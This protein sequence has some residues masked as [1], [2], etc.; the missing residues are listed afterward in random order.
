MPRCVV[1]NRDGRR[2]VA[3]D[4]SSIICASAGMAHAALRFQFDEKK[5]VEALTYIA[6]KWPGITAFFAS[7]V[8]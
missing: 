1:S 5:A 2:S 8:L 7:K 6:S 3:N 4:K